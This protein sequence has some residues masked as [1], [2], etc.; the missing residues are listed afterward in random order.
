MVICRCGFQTVIR[1]S[2]TDANPGRQFHCCP[3]QGTRGC[4]FVAWVIPPI[5]PMCSELL[6]KLDRTTSMNEDVGRKLFAEK[7]K[8][9]SSIFHKLD[10]VFHIHNDQVIRCN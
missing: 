1:T 5:C 7:K 4:G 6:A 10:E 3:R 9:E 2:H 8:T